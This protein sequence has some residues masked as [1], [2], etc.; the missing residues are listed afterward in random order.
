MNY[1]LSDRTGTSHTGLGTSSALGLG[2]CSQGCLCS[3]R[4][5]TAFL[6]LPTWLVPKTYRAFASRQEGRCLSTLKATN[7]SLNSLPSVSPALAAAGAFPW[8]KDG[9]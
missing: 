8:S 4:E 3:T 2:L 6:L 1:S 5:A 7:M 9:M